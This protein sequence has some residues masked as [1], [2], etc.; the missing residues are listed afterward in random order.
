MNKIITWIIGV[1]AVLAL[2]I[3]ISTLVGNNQSAVSLGASGTRFPNGI[4]ADTTSPT[5]G[6][7]RGTTLVTTGRAGIGSTTPSTAGDIVADGTATTTLLL[8]SS[9][10][11]RGT[12][13]QME[14]STG[15]TVA[16]TV[17]GTTISAAATTCK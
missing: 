9:T 3:S 16:I 12:C 15:G 2:G 10:T 17:S 7:V 13:I 8:Q 11:G 5:V 1:I 14:T 6:Q 4:S